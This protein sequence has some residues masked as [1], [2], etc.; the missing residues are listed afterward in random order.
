MV[1]TVLPFARLFMVVGF[2]DVAFRSVMKVPQSG[3]HIDVRLGM[4][5]VL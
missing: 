2:H 4:L 5:H 3:M 1:L